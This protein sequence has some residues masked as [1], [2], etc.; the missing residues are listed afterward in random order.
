MVEMI[1]TLVEQLTIFLVQFNEAFHNLLHHN[2]NLF[3]L[4]ATVCLPSRWTEWS[5]GVVRSVQFALLRRPLLLLLLLLNVEIKREIAQL[6]KRWAAA[7]AVVRS[8]GERGSAR[9]EESLF[10]TACLLLPACLPASGST[11]DS[12]GPD[13]TPRPR[14]AL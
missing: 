14:R 2:F 10:Q 1:L 7:A 13:Q 5:G 9:T 4:C 11:D 3:L 12:P 6:N 8:I